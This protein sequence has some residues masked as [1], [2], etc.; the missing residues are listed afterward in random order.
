MMT[1][2]SKNNISNEIEHHLF[3]RNALIWRG[4]K[5]SG[6]LIFHSITAYKATGYGPHRHYPKKKTLANDRDLSMQIVVIDSEEK[7]NKML[8]VLHDMVGEAIVV[9]SD[10]NVIKYIRRCERRTAVRV[11]AMEF[12]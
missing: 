6:F 1:S 7:I 3:R 2:V 4:N 8:P 12:A 9:M 5:R 11:E 10:V